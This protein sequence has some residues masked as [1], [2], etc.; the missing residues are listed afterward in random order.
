LQNKR[1]V[2]TFY[3]QLLMQANEKIK[4]AFVRVSSALAQR[5]VFG[6]GTGISKASIKDGLTSIRPQTAKAAKRRKP[7]LKWFENC[8]GRATIF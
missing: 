7:I 5:P 8:T 2:V 1:L 4:S 6:I 3:K